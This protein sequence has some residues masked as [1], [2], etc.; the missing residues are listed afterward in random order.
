VIVL[1]AVAGWFVGILLNGAAGF[2]PRY[3]SNGPAARSKSDATFEPGLLKM[4]D[5]FPNWSHRTWLNAGIELF[6]AALFA[7]LWS[8]PLPVLNLLLLS[9]VCS[10]LIL[11]AVIDLR[12]RLV[13]NLLVLPAALLT[14]LA[15][16]LTPGTNMLAVLIGGAFGFAIFAVVALLRP[17][18]LGGGDVKL[19]TL[20]GLAFGFPDALWALMIGVLAGGIAAML[21]LLSDRGDAKSQIPY[22]PFLC[23][24]ALVALFYNPVSIMLYTLTR[25]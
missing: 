22:A 20:I 25:H 5:K 6:S 11:V 3:S 12:Y 1:G 16:Y 19:A 7:W 15:R 21:I 9:L 17:G 8:Q 18:E 4:W 23:L 10:F 2:L 13:L 24:G 14:V